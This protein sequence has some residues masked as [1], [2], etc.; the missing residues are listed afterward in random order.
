MFPC[1]TARVREQRKAYGSFLRT[2]WPDDP[3]DF[4]R[5]MSHPDTCRPI[6][7]YNLESLV[8]LKTI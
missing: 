7:D 8:L 4:L 6:F 2:N 3:T 1:R 5:F